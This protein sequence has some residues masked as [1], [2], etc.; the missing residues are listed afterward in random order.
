LLLYT[1][2]KMQPGHIRAQCRKAAL[3]FYYVKT[4]HSWPVPLRGHSVLLLLLEQNGG[5]HKPE[6]ARGKIFNY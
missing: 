6:S 5:A 4:T 1:A 2:T 3:C